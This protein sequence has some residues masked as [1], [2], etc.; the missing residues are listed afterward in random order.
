MRR[1]RKVDEGFPLQNHH[2]RTWA[3][4]M[5]E[6]FEETMR[7]FEELYEVERVSMGHCKA[8]SIEN[9]AAWMAGRI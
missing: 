7:R 1:R 3:T 6:T 9:A 8:G 2:T 5:T 4:P